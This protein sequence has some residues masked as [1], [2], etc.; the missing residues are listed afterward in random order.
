MLSDLLKWGGK[1]TDAGMRS[2]DAPAPR[3]EPVVGSKAFPKFV[4]SLSQKDA[5][6]LL[7]FGPV[8]GSNVAFCGERLGCKLFIEDLTSELSR[9]LKAGTMDALPDAVQLR[10]RQGDASVDGILCWDFFDFLKKPAAQSVAHHLVGLLRPGG[11]I[12][13]YFAIS[14]VERST[15]TKYEIVNDQSLRHRPHPGAGARHAHPNRDIIKMFEGLVVAESFL[16]KNNCREILLRK[17]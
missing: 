4:A 8:I 2:G 15:Y 17:R 6:V 12:M 11:A 10:L 1:R 13:G 16:L 9:H 3:E 14:N 7:D 5:P